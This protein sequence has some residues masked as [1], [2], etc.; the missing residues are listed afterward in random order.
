MVSGG[1]EDGDL[2]VRL[3]LEAAGQPRGELEVSFNCLMWG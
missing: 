1:G 3:D 2:D